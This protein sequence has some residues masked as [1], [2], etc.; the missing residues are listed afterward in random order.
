MLSKEEISFFHK[1]GYLLLPGILS[2]DEVNLLR[3][4]LLG[5]FRSGEWKRS[6]FNT[7]NVLSDVYVNFPELIGIS[8]KPSVVSIIKS[9]LGDD[10]V[11]MPET[12]VHYKFY[13][14]WH[15]D[16]S[17]QERA[18]KDFHLKPESLMIEAGF[19]LQDN[20]EYGGGLTVMNGSQNTSDNWILPASKKNIFKRISNRIFPIK[21]EK[22]KE[23]NP[24]GHKITDIRSRAGD[25]VI[26]NFR[27]SHR[28]TMPSA[29][30]VDQVPEHKHKLAFFNAFSVNNS[31]ARE[32]LDFICS[33]PEPFY[34]SLSSRKIPDGV[35]KKKDE[36]GITI[37]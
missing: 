2:V 18:G 23:I 31:T 28:A 15:K 17:S 32:Y 14:G 29:C 27:T 25:L 11:L 3:E 20:D 37:Y 26:F 22:N 16:T 30:A 8:L 4:K 21:E 34:R 7:S 36:L 9:L 13:T 24:H 1:E 10:P 5:I 19:Y 33:R 6:P 35:L 12:A